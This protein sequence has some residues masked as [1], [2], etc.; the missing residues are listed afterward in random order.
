MESK[1]EVSSWDQPRLEAVW[2]GHVID[3]FGVLE[4]AV[5]VYGIRKTYV[6]LLKRVKQSMEAIENTGVVRSI[7]SR[8]LVVDVYIPD[9]DFA[10]GPELS[11]PLHVFET[12]PVVDNSYVFKMFLKKGRWCVTSV[13]KAENSSGSHR[14]NGCIQNERKD[15]PVVANSSRECAGGFEH[16]SY[17]G[18]VVGE[19]DKCRFIWT[20][21]L[22]GEGI[23]SIWKNLDIGDWIRFWVM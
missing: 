9:A 14:S 7:N 6:V 18:I 15:L 12:A 23:C 10:N 16:D 20:P 3:R 22:E 1:I 8:E 4:D 17:V 13:T 5:R 11:V 2:V 21:S 19:A